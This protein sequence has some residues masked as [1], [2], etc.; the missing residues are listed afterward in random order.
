M[1]KL[2]FSL[3]SVSI[4]LISNSFA[5]FST[6]SSA[7]SQELTEE[8]AFVVRAHAEPNIKMARLSLG[9]RELA[10]YSSKL[11]QAKEYRENL[12]R[13]TIIPTPPEIIELSYEIPSG[14]E[15][16]NTTFAD[17]RRKK[18]SEKT[19]EIVLEHVSGKSVYDMIVGPVDRQSVYHPQFVQSVLETLP[20]VSIGDGMSLS[21][22]G[23]AN[24]LFFT[25]GKRP[26][27]PSEVWSAK[28]EGYAMI[29]QIVTSDPLLAAEISSL[30]SQLEI[31]F[32]PATSQKNSAV[33]VIAQARAER[34]SSFD[35]V[36]TEIKLLDEQV[37]GFRKKYTE[38]VKRQRRASEIAQKKAQ[39]DKD[40]AE[41]MGGFQVVAAVGYFSED[42]DI[43]NA[44]DFMVDVGTLTSMVLKL[45]SPG[46]DDM[47]WAT[48]GGYA[49]L[50]MAAAQVFSGSKKS[51]FQ[52]TMEMFQQ[53]FEMLNSIRAEMHE[54][55]DLIDKQLSDLLQLSYTSFANI[56]RGQKL[57]SEI[58]ESVMDQTW[59]NYQF[60]ILDK[61]ERA[62]SELNR[63]ESDCLNL[64]NAIVPE[65]WFLDTRGF[66]NCTK[67][68]EW[69]YEEV[70]QL[71][72][73][74]LPAYQVD[75]L[76][77]SPTAV[78]P[79]SWHYLAIGEQLNA[80]FTDS[81][82][83]PERWLALTTYFTRLIEDNPSSAIVISNS[84]PTRL[85]EDG[86]NILEF[87]KKLL[88]DQVE[89]SLF[90][91]RPGIIAAVLDEYSRAVENL[92]SLVGTEIQ[93]VRNEIAYA[94]EYRVGIKFSQPFGANLPDF[95]GDNQTIVACDGVNKR[96][97][98]L[99][100]G[101]MNNPRRQQDFKSRFRWGRDNNKKLYDDLP[102]P[103]DFAV[104]ATEG[105]LLN[106]AFWAANV[107]GPNVKLKVCFE[108]FDVTDVLFYNSL[109][110]TRKKL[111]HVASL[112]TEI[113]VYYDLLLHVSIQKGQE[114]IPV[115]DIAL[116]GS[117]DRVALGSSDRLIYKKTWREL[118]QW[119]WATRARGRHSTG[120]I[121]SRWKN[122]VDTNVAVVEKYY[123]ESEAAIQKILLV[124]KNHIRS[125][126]S[127]RFVG[128]S[129]IHDSVKDVES[130]L[131]LL[132]V[133]F[134]IGVDDSTDE[135]L[136]ALKFLSVSAEKR[137]PGGLDI[138]DNMLFYEEPQGNSEAKIQD[139][140]EQFNQALQSLNGTK[141]LRPSE[142]PTSILNAISN[143]Q[144]QVDQVSKRQQAAR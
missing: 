117:L 63:F 44:A 7:I 97:I 56:R 99:N 66:I 12:S 102:L 46:M 121:N 67:S 32:D 127:E 118:P 92:V 72:N 133:A 55:F 107:G 61:L 142:D 90:Q 20:S 137:L 43:K 30:A 139:R 27:S 134:F 59:K 5:I 70:S 51:E 73:S 8:Q 89:D 28:N 10:E 35:A 104:I 82:V 54:R 122:L 131:N 52:V 40:H 108:K 45:N 135:L 87:R 114:V 110:G 77:S 79:F 9:A 11:Y 80:G 88:L 86:I 65:Y 42:P 2:S 85:V 34:L 111:T 57:N 3:L 37:E 128:P 13:E 29:H 33:V 15:A 4:L 95:R 36:Q 31:G 140:I 21:P 144:I 69:L 18:L 64:Q 126:V 106:Q 115:A 39:F 119:I 48:A 130:A 62:Q 49:G 53:V 94:P 136:D 116:K 25:P 14:S 101:R 74:E 58:L 78:I 91:F 6:A 93:E 75:S 112:F 41:V 141:A 68:F 132:R 98:R 17:W 1:K 129:V 24:P 105:D 84:I 26:L 16:T 123:S 103:A 47:P 138:L 120:P 83:I 23:L 125:K 109:S 76:A 100:E 113:D 71:M 81:L 143:L 60:L 19:S 38:E 96:L 22:A 50:A 124:R